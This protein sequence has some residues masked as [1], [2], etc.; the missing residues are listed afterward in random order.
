L[1]PDSIRIIVTE[2]IQ[3]IIEHGH[4]NYAE[5]ELE[6]NNACLNPY[7]K[8]SFKHGMPEGKKYTLTQIEENAKND[9]SA[10]FILGMIYDNGLIEQSI[11]KD[12]AKYW[13]TKSYES[14]YS[15]AIFIIKNDK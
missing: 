12:K 1:D 5:I 14:E 8:T 6:I 2:A 7:F 4:G 10:Q 9:E 11:D 3:N 13:Y 15:P